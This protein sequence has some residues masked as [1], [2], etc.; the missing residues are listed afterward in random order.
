MVPRSRAAAEPGRP[1]HTA[2]PAPALLQGGPMAQTLA[3][4]GLGVCP[5]IPTA[6]TPPSAGCCSQVLGVL[7]VGTV[8]SLLLW[9]SRLSRRDRIPGRAALKAQPGIGCTF[10]SGCCCPSE[11]RD[12]FPFSLHT[13]C[14]R[15]CFC[16]SL[17]FCF[18]FLFS[19]LWSKTQNRIYH[20]NR[21]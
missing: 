4:H 9:E 6:H 21:F 14:L 13:Y 16:F 19:F 17:V 12:S 8:I 20:L 15:F 3:K 1:L 7:P 18:Y 5:W 10:L 11:P 2:S